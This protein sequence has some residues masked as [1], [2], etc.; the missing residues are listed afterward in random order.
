MRRLIH[1]SVNSLGPSAPVKARLGE[2]LA[3]TAINKTKDLFRNDESEVVPHILLWH[4]F[5]ITLHYATS[6]G[7]FGEIKKKYAMQVEY[8][9]II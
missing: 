2:K 6:W 4:G 7:H 5:V 1:F 3:L 8:Q 9:F